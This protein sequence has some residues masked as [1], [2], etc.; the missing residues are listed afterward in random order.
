MDFS[1]AR[2]AVA[3]DPD[4][5]KIFFAVTSDS[6]KTWSRKNAPEFD[7]T[8]KGESF[9]AASGSNLS[10]QMDT[11]DRGY[12]YFL[13]S[14]GK[15]S[16]MYV[17]SGSGKAAGRYP[18]LINQGK[19]SAGANSIA[20]NPWKPDQAFVVGGD[21]SLDSLFYRNSLLVQLNPF[22]QE[23]PLNPPHGYRSCVEWLDEKQIICCGTT[24]VDYSADGGIHWTL[25]STESFHVCRRAKKGHAL[26]LAGAR[27]RISRL[28]W[29]EGRVK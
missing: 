3:G 29:K 1:G 23:S 15:K 7:T 6:G 11:N 2:G 19:E 10:M 27:G 14:G 12:K 17:S 25:I 13:V 28:D 20:I 5:G 18:L 4:G 22:K 8:G 26:F 9:F 24:G 16:Y 21:F